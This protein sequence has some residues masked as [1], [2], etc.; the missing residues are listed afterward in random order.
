MPK[1]L[2]P[3]AG[4]TGLGIA[5]EEQGGGRRKNLAARG[6]RGPLE[7][8]VGLRYAV[9]VPRG[10]VDCRPEEGDGAGLPGERRPALV[11]AGLQ[12][13]KKEKE[14]QEPSCPPRHYARPGESHHECRPPESIMVP[15]CP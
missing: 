11:G 7:A 9:T 1:E 12:A 2:A 3:E 10:D 14:W 15:G 5:P 4:E 6:V 13:G 8:G